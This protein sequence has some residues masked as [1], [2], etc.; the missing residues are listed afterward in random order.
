MAGDEKRKY[1]RIKADWITSIHQSRITDSTLE[2]MKKIRNVSIGGVFIETSALYEQGTVVDF[3]FVVPGRSDVV[4]AQGVVRWVN[5]GGRQDQTEGIGVEFLKVATPHRE[6][7]TQYI[8]AES[9]KEELQALIK[10][11]LHQNLLR[12]YCRKIGETF[13]I[14]VLAQY[15]GCRHPDLL[16]CLKDFA[17]CKIVRFARDS[18]TFVSADSPDVAN[19]IQTWYQTLSHGST[20]AGGTPIT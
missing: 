1:K 14:D 20:P 10:T 18:V 3:E 15:L 7:L 17:T 13:P 6:A 16:E 4:H 8:R 19:G 9:I 11:R 5:K 12:F 2:R